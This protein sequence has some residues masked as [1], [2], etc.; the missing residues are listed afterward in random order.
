MS[1]S[2]PDYTDIMLYNI[3]IIEHSM[4]FV[5]RQKT[6]AERL[7]IADR[8]WRFAREAL[9]AAVRQQ[10]AEWPPEQINREVVR[11]LSHGAF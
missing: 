5:L 9:L 8:L 10:H 4:A 2:G 6:G 7:D 3:E 1:T 11:R